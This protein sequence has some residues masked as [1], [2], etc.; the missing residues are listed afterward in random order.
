MAHD[1]RPLWKGTNGRLVRCDAANQIG[2]AQ[3]RGETLAPN[4]VWIVRPQFPS[5]V[6]RS[7]HWE[8]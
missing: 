3:L 2:M 1:L 5:I 7:D 8:E 4:T 6:T